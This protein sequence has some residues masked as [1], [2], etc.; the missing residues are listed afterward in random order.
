MELARDLP[1][2]PGRDGL[3]ERPAALR[4]S[5]SC[6]G[7]DPL[8]VLGLPLMAFGLCR[9]G[10]LGWWALGAVIAGTVLLPFSPGAGQPRARGRVPADPAAAGGGRASG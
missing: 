8:L 1:D 2:R 10:V 6:F 5:S 7:L 9:A 3:R 4:C